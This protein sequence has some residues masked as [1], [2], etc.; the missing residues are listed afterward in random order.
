[1]LKLRAG[2]GITGQQD[3]IG[4]YAYIGNYFEGATTAQY[5][6]GG[7]YYT[8]YR[9]AGFD[10]NLKW[11]TTKSYNLGLDFGLFK[12]RI[13]GSV[14]VYKK[15]TSDLLATVAVPAGTNFTNQ[16]LTNVGGYG[17]QRS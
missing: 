17:K 10:A 8:V 12:D 1:M 2:W 9:P 16:I 5:A 3:G 14:D 7:Q 13:S 6:F 11:E 15:I 4:D